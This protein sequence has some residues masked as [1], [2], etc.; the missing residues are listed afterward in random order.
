MM[1][2]DWLPPRPPPRVECALQLLAL[3]IGIAT[4][5]M[6]LLGGQTM[7]SPVGATWVDDHIVATPLPPG[8]LMTALDNAY[9]LARE[10]GD[11]PET[12][13][14]IVRQIRATWYATSDVAAVDAHEA[15]LRRR[16]REAM[17]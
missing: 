3:L 9:A 7:P 13:D 16:Y 4:L 17:Q 14:H 15:S 5:A 10:R 1:L 2:A 12:F 11:G 6:I 8:A